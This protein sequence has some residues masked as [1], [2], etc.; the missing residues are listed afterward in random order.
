MAPSGS[1]T[2]SPSTTK[3]VENVVGAEDQ[4][5]T[6]RCCRADHRGEPGEVRVAVVPHDVVLDRGDPQPAGH[7]AVPTSVASRVAASSRTS[8]PLQQAKRTR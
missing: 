3:P 6:A 5:G 7:D 8:S 4:P 1:P 2:R